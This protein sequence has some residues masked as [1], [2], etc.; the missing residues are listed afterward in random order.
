MVT[1]ENQN[2]NIAH[3]LNITFLGGIG[4]LRVRNI[5]K[6]NT[7]SNNLGFTLSKEEIISTGFS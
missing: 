1:I 2:I 7:T 6:A 3:F 5:P 4:L